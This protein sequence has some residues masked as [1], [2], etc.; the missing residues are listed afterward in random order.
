MMV[1]SVPPA[2]VRNPAL[3][4]GVFFIY[5]SEN[6]DYA[7]LVFGRSAVEVSRA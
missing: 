5:I 6:R 2:R 1:F 3:L 4:F 7:E